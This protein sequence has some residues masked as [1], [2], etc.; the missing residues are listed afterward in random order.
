[1]LVSIPARSNDFLLGIKDGSIP[2]LL[3]NRL[4]CRKQV[5]LPIKDKNKNH[6][7]QIYDYTEARFPS[8]VENLPSKI[9]FFCTLLNCNLRDKIDRN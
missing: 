7:K 6:K 9:I 2:Q 4:I 3:W 8:I 5:I 1:M